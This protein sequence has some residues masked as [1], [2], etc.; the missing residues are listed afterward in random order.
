MLIVEG[1]E[2]FQT[3]KGLVLALGNF[4]GVH[5]GH[6]QLIN[7]AIDESR[8][9]G[10]TSSVL[11]FDPH[12]LRVLIPERAPRLLTTTMQKAEILEKMGLDCLV[13]TPFTHEIAGWCPERFVDD[14]LVGTLH[15]S[16]VYV[17]YNYTFGHKG[18]G[19]PEL[20]QRLGKNRGFEVRV[21][22][23]VRVQER[24]VSSSLIRVCLEQ[25]DI[26]AV[27]EFAG[28]WLF[29]DGVVVKGEQRGQ[30]IGFPT[31][32]LQ[33]D[34][35][36]ILPGLG[37]YVCRAYVAGSTYGAVVNVGK[38]PTFHAEYPVSVEAF[39]ID[40]SGDLYGQNMRL[41]FCDRLR[42]EMKFNGP[43]ELIKQIQQDIEKG[44]NILENMKK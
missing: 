38:K 12:P 26:R 23:P 17:G 40:Y 25:G 29:L 30:T 21:V 44:R 34:P 43:D 35:E 37:V 41:E 42:G 5:L 18:G 27:S 39:L 28:R 15:V 7:S 14:M 3:Q 10:G 11:V 32:N 9:N 13:I 19:D 20:L 22:S 6:Q 2:N 4:D 33:S 16:A 31:A 24:I 8:M 1:I 36:V